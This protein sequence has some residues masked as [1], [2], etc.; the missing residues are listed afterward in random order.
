MAKALVRRLI[1]KC[2]QFAACCSLGHRQRMGKGRL[3][4]ISP[5]RVASLLLP[6]HRGSAGGGIMQAAWP[7][8]RD[9]V[10]PPATSRVHLWLFIDLPRVTR[11]QPFCAFASPELLE[12]SQPSGAR[13]SFP[14]CVSQYTL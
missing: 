3:G 11:R 2:G 7:S 4:K 10:R 1:S 14:Y 13:R 5:G 12:H 8:Q 6:R 9:M